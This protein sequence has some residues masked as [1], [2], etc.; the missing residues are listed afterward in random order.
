MSIAS[1]SKKNNAGDFTIPDFE[2]YL[3]VIVTKTAWYWHKNRQIDQWNKI[4][5][6]A[7]NPH[8]FS[9]LIFNKGAKKIHERKDSIF[10]KWYCKNYIHM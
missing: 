4:K 1:L 8:S 10:N 5:S 7:T 2:L 6:S 9:H 3:K